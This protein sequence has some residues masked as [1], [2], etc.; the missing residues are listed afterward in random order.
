MSLSTSKKVGL[1]LVICVLLLSALGAASLGAARR[2]AEASFWVQH[3]E[4]V[5]SDLSDLSAAIAGA[6][7]A[8][9][10]FI[11]TNDGR[12]LAPYRSSPTIVR[13]QLTTLRRK[14]ADNPVQQRHL[15]ILEPLVEAKIAWLAR[16]T[17][18]ARERGAPEAAALMR[19]GRGR[20]LMHKIRGEFHLMEDEEERLMRIRNEAQMSSAARMRRFIV[21]TLALG[22]GFLAAAGVM[23]QRDL[24]GRRR[25]EKALQNLSLVDE[26]TGLANRRGFFL[27]AGDRVGIAD[28]LTGTEVLYF[29]DLDGLKTINDTLGHGAGDEA[30]RAAAD[31]LATVFGPPDVAARL[32]GDEFVALAILSP[33]ETPSIRAER[34]RA[35]VASWNEAPGRSF[36]LAMSLGIVPVT[37]GATLDELIAT[38]DREMYAEK[39]TRRS[40][41]R[42]T[43]DVAFGN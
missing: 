36:R 11:L 28:R 26:L 17:A 14:T 7:S 22:F 10:G 31:L 43:E 41:R 18:A 25:A 19:T 16:L 29:A 20:E 9:R 37:P 4:D 39:Q 35:A 24:L 12:Y 23:I 13:E 5:E 34:L 40:A 30:I 33:G 38:A 15:D 2:T 8:T 1:S 21:L 32:G 27:H 6:E 3:T 42:P